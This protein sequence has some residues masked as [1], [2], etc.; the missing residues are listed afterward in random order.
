MTDTGASCSLSLFSASKADDSDFDI[1]IKIGSQTF[2]IDQTFTFNGPDLNVTITTLEDSEM[3]EE[4][5]VPSTTGSSDPHFLQIVKD[6]KTDKAKFICY[7]VTGKTGDK[8]RIFSDYSSNITVIGQ[9]VDDYYMHKVFIYFP[10]GNLTITMNE[11]Y[12]QSISIMQWKNELDFFQSYNGRLSLKKTNHILHI[13]PSFSDSQLTYKI[14]KSKKLIGG[15]YLDISIEGLGFNYHKTGGLIGRIGRNDFNF[16]DNIQKQDLIT[17][18]KVGI[19]AN[20]CLISGRKENRGEDGTVPHQ[21]EIR[22][23]S[24]KKKIGHIAGNNVVYG[25]NGYIFLP[26]FS[27]FIV[28]SDDDLKPNGSFT[29]EMIMKEDY[30]IQGNYPLYIFKKDFQ[31]SLRIAKNGFADLVYNTESNGLLLTNFMIESLGESLEYIGLTF[32]SQSSK[33]ILY[34]NAE[35]VKELTLSVQLQQS[36]YPLYIGHCDTSCNPRDFEGRIYAF[37]WTNVYREQ[38][39]FNETWE[40]GNCVCKES[41]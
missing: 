4:N 31:I 26:E 37:K 8:I 30:R 1:S 25:K 13:R 38:E 41:Y 12:L 5:K 7:D 34:K 3:E 40:R 32:N 22:D 14:I 10:S 6:K 16:Y 39:Y 21:S 15:Y 9:P 33:L 20:G 35:K 29:I 36:N 19:V 27:K 17:E 2:A 23:L 24:K 28:T 18:E 11:I